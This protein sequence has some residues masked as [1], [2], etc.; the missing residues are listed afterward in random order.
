MKTI[1]AIIL[2]FLFEFITGCE[3]NN[4]TT[5]TNA[6]TGE[7]HNQG[8]SK[9][10][11]MNFDARKIFRAIKDTAITVQYD[12]YFKTKKR[13]RGYDLKNVLDSIVEVNKLDTTS[14][15]AV[16]ECKD[17]Y[18]PT[19]KYSILQ[20]SPKAFI[21]YK[22]AEEEEDKDWPD[23]IVDKFEPFYLVWDNIDSTDHERIWPYGVVN[24]QLISKFD[25][26][27]SIFPFEDNTVI[28]GYN[29]TI[30]NCLKC[31]TINNIGGAMGP[32]LNYPKN[33]TE[34]WN[35]PD[36]KLFIKDPKSFRYN[37]KMPAMTNLSD[38]DI[39]NIIKYL[40][41]IKQNK[42]LN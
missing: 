11:V 18:R 22:D 3:S 32:E 39:E 15:V 5:A 34:Y 28:A 35:N 13:Y 2:L 8:S 25:Q 14:L 6:N 12:A 10:R 21:V 16:F 9:S 38:V 23:T 26:F 41:Y 40:E 31:H 4:T 1:I 42:K 19:L 7:K 33:I 29:L 30:Q 37:S 17:G 36:I 24:I 20:D 27:N